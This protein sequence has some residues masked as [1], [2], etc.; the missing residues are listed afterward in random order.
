VAL[1]QEVQLSELYR[2]VVLDHYRK[3]RGREPIG[4]E[5]VVAKGFNPVCG[6][7]V[8]VKLA[9]SQE[10]IQQA[11]VVSRGCAICTASASIMAEL[12]PGKTL[13]QAEEEAELFRQVMHGKPFPQDRNL[14]DLPALEGV[15]HFPVRVKCALLP[16]MTLKD[17]VAAFRRGLKQ[18][19]TTTE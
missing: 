9:V 10:T 3:P 15:K 11:Q 12:L 18:A 17:A 5:D 8:E 1:H 4:R 13:G 19:Q 16:W 2:E 7:E 14:G 6:D